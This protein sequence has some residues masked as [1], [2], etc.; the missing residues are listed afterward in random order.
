MTSH[1]ERCQRRSR[2]LIL[3]GVDAH[4]L[5]IGFGVIVLALHGDDILTGEVIVGSFHGGAYALLGVADGGPVRIVC[6]LHGVVEGVRREVDVYVIAVVVSRLERRKSMI[7]DELHV[8][9][10]KR[11][12]R[13]DVALWSEI[14]SG[15]ENDVDVLHTG[16][17]ASFL[18]YER[19]G[20]C[21]PFALCAL[22]YGM[23]DGGYESGAFGLCHVSAGGSLAHAEN[24]T[25]T[26]L[27]VHAGGVAP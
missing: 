11:I 4:S 16:S 5:G 10:G 17:L 8:V 15:R 23:V 6:R 18:I 22:R 25:L 14:V 2:L 20:V 26:V 12:A 3:Y 13:L 27:H 19:Y 21:L 1:V 7:I 9:H 24:V